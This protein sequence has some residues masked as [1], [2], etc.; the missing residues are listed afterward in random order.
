MRA[1]IHSGSDL[2]LQ[3]YECVVTPTRDRCA[4]PEQAFQF[5]THEKSFGFAYVTERS[6]GRVFVATRNTSGTYSILAASGEVEVPGMNSGHR[7]IEEIRRINNS[8]FTL[9]VGSGSPAQ[10][11]HTDYTFAEQN[12]LWYL[13]R[14]SYRSLQNCS[15]EIG[16]GSE[17]DVDLKKNKVRI[18]RWKDCKYAKSKI[19]SLTKRDYFLSDFRL[20]VFDE[21][22]ERLGKY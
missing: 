2:R 11:E 17:Y 18:V 5:E 14:I 19:K 4:P 22:T 8:G 20:E 13:V 16:Q 6:V 1:T 7:W 21:I 9:S 15:D 10:P 12:G 3:D